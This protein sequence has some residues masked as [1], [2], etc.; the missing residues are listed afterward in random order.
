MTRASWQFPLPRGFAGLLARAAREVKKFLLIFVY[1]WTLFGLFALHASI[2]LPGES[3]IYG[4]GFAIVNAFVLAKV[5]FFAENLHVGENFRNRP[6][7]YPILFKSALFAVILICFHLIEKVIVGALRGK[8]ISE[9]MPA[10]GSGSLDEMLSVGIIMF[11]VL[12][13][14]FAFREIARIIGE[15]EMRKLLFVHRI[16]LRPVPPQGRQAE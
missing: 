5:M 10:I 7:I 2:L 6:L 9:S 3:I 11:V 12:I 16:E 1:L 4:Q 8:A 15:R 13:P 14:F